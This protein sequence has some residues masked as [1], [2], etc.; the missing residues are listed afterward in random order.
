M[1][2]PSWEG[3]WKNRIYDRVFQHDFRSLTSFADARPTATLEQ[4]AQELGPHVAPVQ[5]EWLLRDEAKEDG[6]VH[7]FARS[8]LARQVHECFP[9]G[10]MRG[11]RVDWYR[12]SVYSD[13]RGC[14]G[15][16]YNAPTNRVWD[17]LK[18]IAHVGWLPSGPDDPIIVQVFREGRF[19]EDADGNKGGEAG[20]P[21]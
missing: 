10:W 6:R 7:R 12:A 5:L 19:P 13:W 20:G 16:E 1:K 4:L 21:A 2:V 18:K 14:V 9:Q 17:S 8:A 15:E 11:D 3:D